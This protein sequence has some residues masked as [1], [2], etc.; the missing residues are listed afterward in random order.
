M[1]DLYMQQKFN[2]SMTLE[3]WVTD[4]YGISLTNTGLGYSG[5]SVVDEKKY[6]LFLLKHQ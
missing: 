3:K 6:L 2:G 4:Q 1:R 5:Y